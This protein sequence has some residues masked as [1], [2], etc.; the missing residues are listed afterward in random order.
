A[1]DGSIEMRGVTFGYRDEPVLRN[2][3][4]SLP[5][6]AQVAIVGQNGAGKSTIV[7]LLLGFYRP[8]QGQVLASGTSY[9]DI[10]IRELRRSIGIVPQRPQFFAGTV[11]ENIAYGSPS[12]T[13]EQ[14]DAAARL[15]LADEVIARL[16][17][18]YDTP[19]GEHGVRLS[20][21]ESQRL[22]IARALLGNPRMLILDEP[23]T[24]LDTETIAAVMR[25]LANVD[26]RPTLLLISHDQ[27]V[28]NTVED[29]Y[30]LGGGTLARELHPMPN[31]A[32][33]AR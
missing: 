13:P 12:A 31:A 25:R 23:T 15:A 24:H 11:R 5:R 33:A 28:V 7:N 4:L 8:Q 16:A 22:A 29:V 30:R 21:G 32:A 3:H 14:I 26:S 17:Q 9:E 2:V 6:G 10:D 19:I 27:T 20:G 18:G 1:F